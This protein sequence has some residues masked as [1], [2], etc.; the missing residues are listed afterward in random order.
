MSVQIFLFAIS[1]L[2][3]KEIS[4]HG[5]LLEPP[6]RS[7]I[8]R[9]D[10]TATPNYQDN[11]NFCGGAYVQWDLNGGLC[12]LCGDSYS[13]PHPQANENTGTFGQGRIVRT[14]QA[15]STIDVEVL[16]T[17]NHLGSFTFSLCALQNINA[18]ESGEDCFEVLPLIDG[19]A[20]YTVGPSDTDVKLSLQLPQGKT[21]DQCVLRWHY[22]TGNNWGDCGD[23]TWA[24]GCGAQETFRNCADVAIV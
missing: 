5:M 16:L 21:C 13:D 23:G 11:Q 12:G 8:W 18:P 1:T 22:R 19:S 9:F 6:N 10:Q 17:K 2:L 14:Y 15:G 4:G 3:V 24:K 7:S 20:Q